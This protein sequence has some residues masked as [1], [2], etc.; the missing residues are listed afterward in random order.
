VVRISNKTER[1]FRRSRGYVPT[2][3]SIGL[4]AEG[5]IAFGAELTNC[6]SVGKGNKAILSQYI[7]DLQGL[8]TTTFYEQTIRQF[9]HLFRITPA[10]LAVDMHPDYI[11]AKTGQNYGDLPLVQVQHHH[12][13]IAS[14][15][16]EHGL[17]EKVIGV[18]LDGTGYGSDANIWGAEFLVCDLLDYRR[19]T[20]FD[21]IPLPGGDLATEEPWRMAVS[22]L[23]RLYGTSLF[24]LELPF[25]KQTD[26]K[27]VDFIIKMI[28]KKINC[29]LV[30]STGRLFDAVS[31]LLNLC[32]VAK[33]PAEG[34]MRLESIVQKGIQE[35]YSFQKKNT[36]LFDST[37]HEIIEDIQHGI[38][39]RKISTKFHNTIISV[40]FESLKDIRDQERINKVVLSGGVFQNEYL[41]TG[42]E[43]ILGN[44]GFKVYSHSAI[45]SNDG[46]IALGQLVIAAKRRELKC[47]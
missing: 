38:D 7:G 14:C 41:L 18:A 35:K 25:L 36:I 4:D 22:Y 39:I 29:P 47:V 17:N 32:F 9:I 23:Y 44:N 40:I 33:F 16:A 28:E 43:S 2:P 30:S 15:M 19:I 24:N 34:P 11:S 21:Y 13:H 46:G 6:F 10:L 20:H 42:V 12:A 37:I 3:V 45:P 5:I 27:K 1:V 31:A 26:P 8:E